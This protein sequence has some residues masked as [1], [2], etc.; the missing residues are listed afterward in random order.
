VALLKRWK[1]KIAATSSARL[2]TTSPTNS[3]SNNKASKMRA[4]QKT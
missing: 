4:S 1:T 3:S 2:M